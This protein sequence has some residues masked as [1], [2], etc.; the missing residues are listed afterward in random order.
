MKILVMG[1]SCRDI[2]V[3]GR[4]DRLE[5]TAPAPVFN[6]I[7]TL[8]NGG[9]AKNV[10]ANLQKMNCECDLFTNKNWSD[11]HKIRYIDFKTN[12]MI[13][14]LDR[15]DKNYEPAGS[16][17][18]R[19]KFKNYDAII[20]SD[21]DKG[22]LT[23][24]DIEYISSKHDLV[25]IDTKKSLGNWC[26]NVKFIKVNQYEYEQ[27]AKGITPE[28]EEKLVVTLGPDGARHNSVIYSVPEVEIKDLSGAGD[29]F[30]SALACKYIKTKSIE[31][32][33]KFANECA[34][35]VVQKRGVSTV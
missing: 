32:S 24:E 20:I 19:I 26:K 25:F 28:I 33:I 21:Y 16:K 31:E 9:M 23:E 18:K 15:N 34:T 35:V 27:S 11:I 4:C 30:I 17:L 13:M 10:Q 1:E 3:Y 6:E 14:R 29:T 22:F 5:P 12:H 7:K 2:F 8:E